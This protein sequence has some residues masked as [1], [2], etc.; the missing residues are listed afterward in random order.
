ME[1]PVQNVPRAVACIGKIQEA[2]R[3]VGTETMLDKAKSLKTLLMALFRESGNHDVEGVTTVNACYG[4]TNAIFNTLN[5][6]ES[7]AWDGRYG[8]VISA[9]VATRGG[10][11]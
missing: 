3:A 7:S 2:Y 8:I 6:V 5:W 4:S 10:T 9:D 1:K 11:L